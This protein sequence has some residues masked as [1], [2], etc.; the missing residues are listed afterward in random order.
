MIMSFLTF[1]S[2][3]YILSNII[4]QYHDSFHYF[5]VYQMRVE[6]SRPDCRARSSSLAFQLQSLSSEKISPPQQYQQAPEQVIQRNLPT[7][8]PVSVPI[9]PV[10]SQPTA[11]IIQQ[12]S[13]TKIIQQPPPAN[14]TQPASTNSFVAVPQTQP[15]QHQNFVFNQS[16]PVSSSSMQNPNP[17]GFKE[18]IEVAKGYIDT[19]NALVQQNTAHLQS[20][21]QNIHNYQNIGSDNFAPESTMSSG[22][23]LCGAVNSSTPVNTF[24]QPV[25]RKVAGKVCR[26]VGCNAMS[27]SRRPYC[28]RHSGNRLCEFNGCTKCAQGATRFCIAHGGGR[29]CTFPGCDKG[30]RDKFFC[31]AHGGGK[32]CSKDGCTKSAV[33]GSNLCTSH[34]GGRRCAIDGCMKSAQSSTKFCVKHGGGKKCIHAGC[35]KVARG[36][37]LYCAGHGGGVR[38]KLEG[39]S[40]IAIGKMQLCRAH[41]G[42]SS[43]AKSKATKTVSPQN[44]APQAYLQPSIVH[45][46]PSGTIPQ[47][48][49]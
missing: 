44:V 31:A 33:G 11:N 23:I 49:I 24:A 46:H 36:R 40:R 5:T 29:R 47:P 41:G 28:A 25:T 20:T 1:S 13:P 18:D 10:V 8:I 16:N 12:P 2:L 34:G 19:I 4:Y 26:I 7:P 30:A 35:E 6:E 42:G 38:C 45:T 15:Q 32:R 39:C 21:G 9:A 37:T 3:R 22:T 27:V 48:P 43:R 14:I 17:N